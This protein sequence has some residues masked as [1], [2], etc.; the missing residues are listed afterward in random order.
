MCACAYVQHAPFER[1]VGMIRSN[2]TEFEA[3]GRVLRLKQYIKADAGTAMIDAI[4]AALAANTHVEA[5]YIQNF[6]WVRP[7]AHGNVFS[8]Q[9][10]MKSVRARLHAAS[11]NP[12]VCGG[13]AATTCCN[14]FSWMP[15]WS[16]EVWG[17]VRPGQ[18]GADAMATCA[19]HVR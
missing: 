15:A 1:F 7:S 14:G 18:L 11:A 13:Q 3:G 16:G 9:I 10:L 6:E 2:S 5:L 17:V 19:G 12:A 8:G 4:I